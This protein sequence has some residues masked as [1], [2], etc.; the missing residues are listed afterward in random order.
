[1]RE[2]GAIL[3]G[4][5]QVAST[6]QCCHCGMHWTPKPGS[7]TIRGFCLGCMRATCGAPDCDPCIPF[8]AWLDHKAGKRTRYTDAILARE[9]LSGI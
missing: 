6:I 3:I 1:M 2:D 4:D 5:K 9:R 8:E 7:G